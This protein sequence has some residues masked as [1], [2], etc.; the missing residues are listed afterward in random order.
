M[1]QYNYAV[2]FTRMTPPR[3][4]CV[5]IVSDGAGTSVLSMADYIGFN[6]TAHSFATN[7]PL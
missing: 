1:C 4:D 2:P 6:V 5:A 3:V 7:T